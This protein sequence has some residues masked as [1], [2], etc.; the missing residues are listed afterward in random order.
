MAHSVN[1][2]EW[3]CGIVKVNGCGIVKVNGCGIVNMN[4]CGMVGVECEKERTEIQAQI[5]IVLYQLIW[6][7]LLE[8]LT[9]HE[10]HFLWHVNH[11]L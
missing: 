7:L 6:L 11:V 8:K 9:H 2:S 4:G 1:G 5:I 10:S 3:V